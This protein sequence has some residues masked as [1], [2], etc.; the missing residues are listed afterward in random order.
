M[1]SLR[2]YRHAS[3]SI[4]AKWPKTDKE[5]HNIKIPYPASVAAVHLNTPF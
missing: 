4:C 2:S 5:K 1:V 3:L